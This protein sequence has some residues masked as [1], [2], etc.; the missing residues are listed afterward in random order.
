VVRK[1]QFSIRKFGEQRAKQLAI[2]ARRAGV[3]SMKT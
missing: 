3:A 2:R 1:K